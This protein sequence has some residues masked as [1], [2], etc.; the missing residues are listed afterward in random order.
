LKILKHYAFSLLLLLS[1]I[2]GGI[3][4]CIEKEQA[5]VLKPL[6]DIFL[7]LLFTVVV[8][9]VFFSVA[10]SIGSIESLQ[11]LGKIMGVMIAVFA[12]M[13]I[14]AAI[15]MLG[16]T[17]LFP[18]TDASSLQAFSHAMS[19]TSPVF[20][21]QPLGHFWDLLTVS[22]FPKLFSRENLLALILFSLFL[23]GAVA[24]IGEKGKPFLNFLQAGMAVFMKLTTWVMYYAPIGFFAYF[25]VLV[26]QWGKELIG[27]YCYI[28]CVYYLGVLVYLIVGFTV[29][30]WIA[31]R[32]AG[33]KLFWKNMLPPAITAFATCSSAASLPVN[34]EAAENMHV[35]REIANTVIPLG[36]MIH[37]QGSIMGGIV[38][39][40]FLFS[41]FHLPFTDYSSWLMAIG[42]SLLVG[43][44][45]GAIP[46]GGMLGEMLILSVYGFPKEALM[47]IAV[48]SLII[49]PPATLLNVIGNT[50][51]SLL[52]GR[53]SNSLEIETRKVYN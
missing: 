40:V 12:G 1:V 21:P 3:T 48:I 20:S 52:V 49:D 41:F 24:S 46:S 22:D 37:K 27:A 45:M 35:H 47:L 8:P 44:V 6:G 28:G 15:Y 19:E 32:K 33:V 2:L 26:G 4:G 39:I 53:Y 31:K 17:V 5:L 51:S 16:V 23:G 36:T 18:L 42:V 25:A 10:S 11:R 50:L 38:K 29:F 9:L 14:I 13:G 34:L 7:N 30:A 43:T